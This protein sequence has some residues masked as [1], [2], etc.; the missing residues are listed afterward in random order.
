MYVTH[1]QGKVC[2]LRAQC[3]IRL[4]LLVTASPGKRSKYQRENVAQ[5][6]LYAQSHL[7]Q[8]PSALSGG[9]VTDIGNKTETR[10]DTG[11]TTTTDNRV[12]GINPESDGN[13]NNNNSSSGSNA[14]PSV[15]WELGRRLVKATEAGEEAAIR[16]VGQNYDP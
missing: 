13:N 8:T 14:D 10:T 11:I 2:F 1:I 4:H 5:L 15:P 12:N 3:A 9:P 16:E 6:Y 7:I